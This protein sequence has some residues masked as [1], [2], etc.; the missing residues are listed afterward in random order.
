MN[1]RAKVSAFNSSPDVPEQNSGLFP[2]CP[3][4]NHLK[5]SGFFTYHQGLTFKNSTCRSLCVECF[6][7]I[8]EQTATFV[9]DSINWLVFITVVERVYCA[10]R[11]G[12]L[13]KAVCASSL[14]GSST[15]IQ[16]TQHKIRTLNFLV[17]ISLRHVRSFV[18]TEITFRTFYLDIPTGNHI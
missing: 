2:Y 14:K 18:G 11:T 5:S 7:R 10:V 6:V 12:S 3:C 8:S 16:F 4:I 1:H 17:I 13:N 9:L 15:A